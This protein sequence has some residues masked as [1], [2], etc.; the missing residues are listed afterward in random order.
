MIYMHHMKWTMEDLYYRTTNASF[1][2]VINPKGGRKIHVA[3]DTPRIRQIRQ[4]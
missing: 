3:R 2:S 4:E 1:Q